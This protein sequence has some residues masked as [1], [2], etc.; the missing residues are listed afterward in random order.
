C[1]THRRRAATF[2][3]AG[4]KRSGNRYIAAMPRDADELA[5]ALEGLSDDEPTIDTSPAPS[6]ASAPEKRSRTKPTSTTSTS[7]PAAPKS[8]PS[9]PASPAARPDAPTLSPT[10]QARLRAHQQS[11]EL[12]RTLIPPLLTVGVIMLVYGS[13]W[14]VLPALHPL[15]LAG[16]AGLA[17]VLLGIGVLCVGLGAMNML[18]VKRAIG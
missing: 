16:T 18:G 10:A 2:T 17:F 8:R 3:A 7:R 13:V 5:R 6:P 9:A 14:F 12:K 11:V 4:D 15:R 1:R